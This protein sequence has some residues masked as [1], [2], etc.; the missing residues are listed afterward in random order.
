MNAPLFIFTLKILLL[1]GIAFLPNIVPS[2]NYISSVGLPVCQT[3]IRMEEMIALPKNSFYTKKLAEGCKYCEKGS[4]MVLLVTGLCRSNCFYCPLSEKKKNRDVIYANELLIKNEEK[5]FEEAELMEAEGTG[6]TGGDPLEVVDR[7]ARIIEMLKEYFG[8][9]HHIHLYTSIMDK[10][11]I[12]RLVRAGL[13][14][15]R[16]HPPAQT[17]GKI[18]STPLRKIA[19]E[20]EIDVGIEIPLIPHLKGETMHLLKSAE[21]YDIDFVN[22]NE[23]EFSETNFRRMEKYGY[24]VKSDI[25]NA[26]KGSEEMAYDILEWDISLPLHYCSSSFKDGVQLRNRI[27][28]RA[29][30]VAKLYDIITEDGTLLK[31]VISAD[32]NA[33]EKI[34]SKFSI[35]PDMMGWDDEKERIETSPFI[36]Q[37][38][39]D[40]LPYKCYIVEEYP[41]A[42]RLEVE[43]EPL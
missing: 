29:R 4:K 3:R 34:R 41:T 16:F 7:T 5:I 28:R 17:W 10:Q 30:N 36:L 15:I 39:S 8:S 25:S 33:L 42:D 1:C 13:D 22:L 27:M 12:E 23:L 32:R 31:G 2:N 20:S 26:V 35:S 19:E 6:I 38:I 43:I 37:D 24:E 18:D 21:K 14:E 9:A 40:K 11:K